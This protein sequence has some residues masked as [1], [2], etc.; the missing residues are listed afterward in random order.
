MW[1]GYVFSVRVTLFTNSNIKVV[2]QMHAFLFDL[3]DI[4]WVCVL[5]CQWLLVR[6]K[7]PKLGKNCFWSLKLQIC[8]NSMKENW[9]NRFIGESQNITFCTI[10]HIFFSTGFLRGK[11]KKRKDNNIIKLYLAFCV[12]SIYKIYIIL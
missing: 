5:V 12:S 9:W 11:A 6:N 7:T 8:A 4:L 2:I 10:H 3:S 1:P